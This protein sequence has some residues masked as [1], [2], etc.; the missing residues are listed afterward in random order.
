MA[1]RAARAGAHQHEPW[2]DTVPQ[3][4]PDR[5]LP[6]SGTAE[7]PRKGKERRG[8]K[9]R[10]PSSVVRNRVTHLARTPSAPARRDSIRPSPVQMAYCELRPVVSGNT[11]LTSPLP[12]GWTEISQPMLLP[13]SSR[14]ALLTVPR[15]SGKAW[16]GSLL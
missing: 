11:M 4:D 5:S 16:S 15:V 8:N 3:A 2:L 12:L 10:P 14:R 9:L 7:P 13:C 6:R 1:D